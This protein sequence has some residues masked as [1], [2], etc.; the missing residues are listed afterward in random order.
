MRISAR[1]EHSVRALL[2]LCYIEGT[3]S[4]RAISLANSL[5]L[6]HIEYLI[7]ILRKAKIVSGNPGAKGG[8]KLDK[9]PSDITLFDIIKAV[10]EDIDVYDSKHDPSMPYYC[11]FEQV[12][13]NISLQVVDYYKKITLED[14]YDKVKEK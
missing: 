14:I 12:W 9:S 11:K 3:A 2:D 4:L 5:P 6:G 13:N 7:K 10:E 1:T 8:Y